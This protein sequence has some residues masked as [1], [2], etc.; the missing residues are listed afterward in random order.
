MFSSVSVPENITQNKLN[1][2]LKDLYETNYF[3]DVNVKILEEKIIITVKEN[4]IVENIN[5]DA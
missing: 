2:I 4:P 3:E 5:F 1:N